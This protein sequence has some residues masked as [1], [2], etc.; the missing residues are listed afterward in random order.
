MIFY[1]VMWH[2]NKLLLIDW[3]ICNLIVVLISFVWLKCEKYV[4][5]LNKI[6]SKSSQQYFLVDQ[7]HTPNHNN[8]IWDKTQACAKIID[9]CIHLKYIWLI[10]VHE[11]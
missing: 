9:S 6:I 5:K 2:F 4:F 1:V 3:V 7:S 8:C 10:N 11:H